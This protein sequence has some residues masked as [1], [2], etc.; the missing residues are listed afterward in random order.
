[1][2]VCNMGIFVRLYGAKQNVKDR[3]GCNA[4]MQ[5]GNICQAVRGQAERERQGRMATNVCLCFFPV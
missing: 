2:H 4:C 5:Y 3:V 1:M